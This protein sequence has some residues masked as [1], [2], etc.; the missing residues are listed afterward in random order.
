MAPGNEDI[1]EIEYLWKENFDSKLNVW[2]GD[3]IT[4]CLSL[5]RSNQRLKNL[6]R[7]RDSNLTESYTA[8]VYSWTIDL[9]WSIRDSLRLG[10]DGIISNEVGNVIETLNEPEFKYTYHLATN[11]DDPFCVITEHELQAL[12][13]RYQHS[14]HKLINNLIVTNYVLQ[15]PGEPQPPLTTSQTIRPKMPII[16]NNFETDNLIRT[17]NDFKRTSLS[18]FNIRQLLSQLLAFLSKRNNQENYMRFRTIY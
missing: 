9:R 1:E 6:L 10:V 4:N 2:Q 18:D 5:L 16:N 14:K 8:K 15:G 11:E 3:G 17:G 13:Q 7:I 12:R